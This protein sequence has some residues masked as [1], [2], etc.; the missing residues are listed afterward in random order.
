MKIALSGFLLSLIAL[1]SVYFYLSQFSA[2]TATL[3]QF[4]PLLILL[5]Y[6]HWYLGDNRV[7]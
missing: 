2:L 3:I 4:F 5:A 1:Q 6:R 7:D